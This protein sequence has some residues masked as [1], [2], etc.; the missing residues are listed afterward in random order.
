MQLIPE[1]FV[2]NQLTSIPRHVTLSIGDGIIW[3]MTMYWCMGVVY[4]VKGYTK[5][6]E[7]YGL[8]ERHILVMTYDG[9]SHFSM[10]VYMENGVQKYYRNGGL[11]EIVGKFP[12]RIFPLCIDSMEF[13]EGLAWL[14]WQGTVLK[15]AL[16]LG[17][18]YVW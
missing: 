17:L 10:E 7:T 9:D 18:I 1:L 11:A 12:D 15:I 3:H 6:H 5:F 14:L 2:D 13:L 16:S 4:L 8:G